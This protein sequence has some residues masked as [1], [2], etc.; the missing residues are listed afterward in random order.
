MQ[1]HQRANVGS[2]ADSNPGNGCW[3]GW[4]KPRLHGADFLMEHGGGH[5][6]RKHQGA[7]HR[8]GPLGLLMRPGIDMLFS[9]G[10]LLPEGLGDRILR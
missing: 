6:L 4:S 8:F 2:S 3:L 5:G 1:R 7:R 10:G 9:T